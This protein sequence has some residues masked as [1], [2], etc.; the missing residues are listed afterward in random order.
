MLVYFILVPS[1]FSLPWCLL[2][3]ANASES[4]DERRCR[5][6]EVDRDEIHMLSLERRQR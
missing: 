5:L 3:F 4:P 1:H 2:G 6:R